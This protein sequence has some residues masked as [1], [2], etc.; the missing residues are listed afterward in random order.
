MWVLYT[1]GNGSSLRVGVYTRAYY[2][3]H[4]WHY[5]TLIDE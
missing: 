2:V 5:P 4:F 3:S 1:L